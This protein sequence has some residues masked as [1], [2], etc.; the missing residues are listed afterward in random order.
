MHLYIQGGRNTAIFFSFFKNMD[1]DG[2]C[3]Q[4]TKS[5]AFFQSKNHWLFPRLDKKKKKKKIQDTSAV[6]F[7]A[8]K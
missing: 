2:S 3:L 1:L 6:R 4:K 8:K 5:P 7:Y